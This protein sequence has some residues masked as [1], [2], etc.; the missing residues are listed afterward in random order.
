MLLNIHTATKII[1]SDGTKVE[2]DVLVLGTGWA[3]RFKCLEKYHPD[4]AKEAALGH[5]LFRK[6]FSTKYRE[7][8]TFLGL[9]RPGFGAMPPLADIQSRWAA[10]VVSGIVK[11]P[12]KNHMVAIAKRDERRCKKQYNLKPN[13]ITVDFLRFN[14]GIAHEMGI[15]PN[16]VK[17]F[18]TDP[19]LWWHLYMGPINGP[20]WR[21]V[22]PGAK[23]EWAREVIVRGPTSEFA[24]LWA[25]INLTFT[26]WY[27]LGYKVLGLNSA[28]KYRPSTLFQEN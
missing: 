14:S 10:L 12:D 9:A 4:I 1:F 2:A 3:P 8:L 25:L 7:E 27:I 24:P 22:G 17:I 11:L 20:G 23:P 26:S 21:L 18:F 16:L 28:K 6:T 15:R 19:K 5:P 13:P